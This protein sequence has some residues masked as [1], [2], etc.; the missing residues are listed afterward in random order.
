MRQNWD[1]V[2]GALGDFGSALQG[3]EEMNKSFAKA[4]AAVALGLAIVNTA[5]GVTRAFKDYPW[6]F[7]MVVAGLIGAAGAIQIATIAATKFAVGTPNVPNDMI[8]E[9]HRGE[10]IIPATFADAIRR[11]ELSL[12]GGGNTGGGGAE[13]NVNVYY[14]R[15]SSQEE[16]KSLANALGLEI[17]RQLRYL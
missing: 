10:T 2:S 13:I 9:V 1:A 15:M 6:P 11:G 8:A 4:A 17:E 12:S 14:P 3:A 7:S 16:V 5:S